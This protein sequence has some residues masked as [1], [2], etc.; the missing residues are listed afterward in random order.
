MRKL[1]FRNSRGSGV[2][3]KPEGESLETGAG[4]DDIR[5][6]APSSLSTVLMG[7]EAMLDLTSE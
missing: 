6:R 4:G 3:S 2:S 7:R 1:I 5:P